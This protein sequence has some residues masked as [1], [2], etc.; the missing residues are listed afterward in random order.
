M[1]LAV[2]LAATNRERI[3][4]PHELTPGRAAARSSGSRSA[5]PGRPAHTIYLD[6]TTF[7]LATAWIAERH[8]R[9]PATTNPYLLVTQQTAADDTHPAR[10]GPDPIQP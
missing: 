2:G 10:Y 6:E 1:R 8:R 5:R 9:W 4:L 3:L 7:S